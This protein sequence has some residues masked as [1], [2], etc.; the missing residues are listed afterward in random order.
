MT[1]HDFTYLSFKIQIM[2]F[3]SRRGLQAMPYPFIKAAEI[4]LNKKVM[5]KSF[6]FKIYRE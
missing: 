1:S 5:I 3:E 2:Y 6:Y 4:L